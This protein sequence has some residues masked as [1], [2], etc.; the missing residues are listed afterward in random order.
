MSEVLAELEL[1]LLKS[2]NYSGIKDVSSISHLAIQ[3]SKLKKETTV[4]CVIDRGSRGSTVYWSCTLRTGGSVAI[5]QN[6]C[7]VPEQ[8]FLA[9]VITMSSLDHENVVKLEGYCMTDDMDYYVYE[10]ASRRSLHTILHIKHAYGKD[11]IISLPW[12]QRI[13]IGVEVAKGL[14]YI[15]DEKDL[16]HRNIKSNN[17]LIFEDGTAKIADLH[18]SNPC[19]CNFPVPIRGGRPTCELYHPPEFSKDGDSKAGDVYSFGVVLL[20]L[21]TGKQPIDLTLPEGMNLVSW[22]KPHLE[23]SVHTV[24]GLGEDYPRVA[25]EKMAKVIGLCLEN[26][27]KYR[28]TMGKVLKHL[29]KV[30][31]E[32]QNYYQN[33]TEPKGRTLVRQKQ[34][35]GHA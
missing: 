18:I 29:R 8:A 23:G 3:L 13:K 16:I 11:K 2:N 9:Q 30:L 17:V 1:A 26:E 27:P 14:C 15:H 33:Q 32:T 12:P 25:V 24:V 5:K 28:P 7:Q 10:Y 34:L 19:S 6:K 31:D 20:E 4:D 35:R 22:A 21:L